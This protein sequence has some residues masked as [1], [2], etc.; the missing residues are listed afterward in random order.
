MACE[1]CSFNRSPR[2]G[3]N[4]QGVEPPVYSS[5]EAR[6]GVDSPG[7]YDVCSQQSQQDQ[8]VLE[9]KDGLYCYN[10]NLSAV[11]QVEPPDTQLDLFWQNN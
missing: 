6:G 1:I 3:A 9:V 2:T 5:G 4:G 8:C 10:D 7:E 11:R